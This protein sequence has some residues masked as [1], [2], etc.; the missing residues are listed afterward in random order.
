MLFNSTG[1]SGC[2]YSSSPSTFDSS[3]AGVA[4][5]AI[6]ASASSDPG[7]GTGLYSASR[8]SSSSVTVSNSC[9]NL[10]AMPIVAFLLH[11]KFASRGSQNYPSTVSDIWSGIPNDCYKPKTTEWIKNGDII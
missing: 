8:S 1:T 9:F 7:S 6:A 3:G 4:A 5:A 10:T 11:S 2:S